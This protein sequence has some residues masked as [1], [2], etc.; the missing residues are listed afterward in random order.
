MLQPFQIAGRKGIA[1][2]GARQA[3]EHRLAQVSLGQACHRGVDRCERCRQITPSGFESRVQHGAPQKPAFDL[4]AHP[5]LV[6]YRERLLLRAI[7]AEETQGAGV[8]AVVHGHD[9]LAARPVAHFLV[10]DRGFNL[11]RGAIAHVDELDDAGFILVAQR[12]VQSQVDVPAQSQLFEGFLR[13][14]FG[15]GVRHGRIVPHYTGVF[16]CQRRPTPKETP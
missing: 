14:G 9:E 13:L 4:S 7:E 2:I 6:A 15:L 12:Q 1:Q 16:A 10:G 5:H 8:G 11:D 3:G